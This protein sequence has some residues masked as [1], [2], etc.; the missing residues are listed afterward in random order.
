M[1]KLYIICTIILT[2]NKLVLTDMANS[3]LD[4]INKRKYNNNLT[5]VFHYSF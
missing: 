1:P 4:P 3:L 2:H 5:S